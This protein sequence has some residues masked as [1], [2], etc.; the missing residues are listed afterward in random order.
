MF[1]DKNLKCVSVWCYLRV[2]V[3]FFL[4]LAPKVFFIK[5]QKNKVLFDKFF[6]LLGAVEQY[7]VEEEMTEYIKVHPDVTIDELDDYFE[8]IVPPGLP[9]CSSEWEDDEDDE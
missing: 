1:W 6:F 8:E 7:E 3:F 5:N 4:F 9:P 2:I